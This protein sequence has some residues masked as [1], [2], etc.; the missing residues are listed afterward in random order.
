M[1]DFVRIFLCDP[2]HRTEF[3]VLETKPSSYGV[4]SAAD[5]QG[6][7]KVA[8]SGVVSGYSGLKTGAVYYSD[9]RGALV[10]S[11]LYHGSA[12]VAS[13]V[14]EYV[15]SAD[16]SKLLSANGL[17]GTAVSPTELYI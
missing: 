8:A 17:V 3:S 5:A 1:I 12:P 7:I 6:N 2:W 14:D 9:S 13:S 16:G 4:I 11:G 10:N 15:Q